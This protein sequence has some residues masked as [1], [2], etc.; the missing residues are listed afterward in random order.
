MTKC[1]RTYQLLEPLKEVHL[2]AIAR[3]HGVYGI[4]KLKADASLSALTVGWD[5]SRLSLP[6]VESILA[7]LGLPL[8]K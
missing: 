4:Q 6:Q 5:A 3:A 2:E 7:G 8:K 1:E